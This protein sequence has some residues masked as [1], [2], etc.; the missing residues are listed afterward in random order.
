VLLVSVRAFA[1]PSYLDPVAEKQFRDDIAKVS[2]DA[3]AAW[4]AG[5]VV[6]DANHPAD[7]E[8]AY[9]KALALAPNVDHIH[10]R[11]CGMLALQSRL[12]EAVRECELA[13]SLSP[14]S[15]YDKSALASSLLAR[16]HVDDRKRGIALAHEGAVALPNDLLVVEVDCMARSLATD[17]DDVS[18]CVDHLLALA[19]DDV[20]GNDYAAVLALNKGDVHRANIYLDKAK[21]GGLPESEYQ[22]LRAQIESYNKRREDAETPWISIDDV[23]AIGIPVVLGWC[24]LLVVLLMVG[25][26]LS[27]ATLRRAAQLDGIRRSYRLVLLLVAILFYVSLPGLLVAVLAA[28]WLVMYAFD[29]A[30]ATPIIVLIGLG[31]IV[32]STLVAVLRALFYV[33]PPKLEGMPIDLSAFP[34]LQALLAE[35]AEAVGTRTVDLVYL[36]P[37]VETEILDQRTM[38]QALRGAKGLRI[39]VLGVGLFDGM[40]QRELRSVLAHEYGEVADAGVGR[41]L[42]VQ[43]SLFTVRKTIAESRYAFFNPAWWLL[44][45][46]THLYVVIARGAA[47]IQ[48]LLADRSAIRAY[49]SE[50]FI[51]G[52]RH[53]VRRG[54]EFPVDLGRTIKDVVDNKWSLPN[55]YAYEVENRP[56]KTIEA[57]VVQAMEASRQRIELAAQLALPGE[58]AVADG[59]EPVWTLFPEP[60]QVERDMTAIIRDRVRR[61]MGHTI[62]DAEWDDEDASSPS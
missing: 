15:G 24:L 48:D 13:L 18:A 22:K 44:R 55:L 49:G 2:A 33:P 25:N 38:G 50:T 39:L 58:R 46:F 43:R 5:N 16:G 34:K 26:S 12:D 20:I 41:A 7:A 40:K 45:A 14:S 51:A 10:R 3:A 56:T 60:E 21:A 37:G 4:D 17:V 52:R 8:A 57:K 47:R 54:V 19:P 11:L 29:Q 53:V 36:V 61:K 28:A 59:D 23:L 27:G 30:G 62:S 35:T 9:R 42:G 31:A 1:A 32:L 6:R